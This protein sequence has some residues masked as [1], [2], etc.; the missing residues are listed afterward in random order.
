MEAVYRAH[1]I[2][3]PPK[4]SSSSSRPCYGEILVSDAIRVQNKAFLIEM[5]EIA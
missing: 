2:L 5:E 4:R 1:N 3:G